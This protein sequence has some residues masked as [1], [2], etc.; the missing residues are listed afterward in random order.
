MTVTTPEE[1]RNRMREIQDPLYPGWP[2]KYTLKE[3]ARNGTYWTSPLIARIDHATLTN[4]ITAP[5]RLWQR[6]KMWHPTACAAQKKVAWY[7]SHV[8]VARQWVHSDQ[9]AH[10]GACYRAT[11]IYEK[12]ITLLFPL[13]LSVT[14]SSAQEC[15]AWR[16]PYPCLH[17]SQTVKSR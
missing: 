10:I 6:V 4:Q 5:A 2:Q 11:D 16:Q 14:S 15:L 7:K 1:L 9:R 13:K 12:W 8:Y 3:I 17:N